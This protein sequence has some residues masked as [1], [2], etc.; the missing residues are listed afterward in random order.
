MTNGQLAAI[1]SLIA[2]RAAIWTHECLAI[3]DPF[4]TASD[5]SIRQV[6]ADILA[7]M[8]MLERKDGV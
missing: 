7:A 8:L 3:Q 5:N 4:A 2:R 1:T 6:K